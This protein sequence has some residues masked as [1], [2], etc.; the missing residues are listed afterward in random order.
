MPARYY[1][2]SKQCLP[3]TIWIQ[4]NA[5]P[6]LF[7][8]KAMPARYYVDSKQCLPVTMWIQSNAC[9]LLFGFKAMPA[10]Y[11]LDSKAR[12]CVGLSRQQQ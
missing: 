7:G 1:L 8:F 12:P 4:S 2:D 10:R 6:L 11:Y 5:C 3:V 9:P